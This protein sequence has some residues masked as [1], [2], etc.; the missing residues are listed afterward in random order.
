[1]NC[2][3]HV[4]QRA[5][6][7]SQGRYAVLESVANCSDLISQLGLPAKKGLAVEGTRALQIG[8]TVSSIVACRET[9]LPIGVFGPLVRVQQPTSGV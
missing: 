7:Q 9:H 6:E 2:I 1:M 4:G 5:T 3:V 8:V